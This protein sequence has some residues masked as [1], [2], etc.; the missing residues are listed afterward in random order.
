MQSH[1]TT[2]D[3]STRRHRPKTLTVFAAAFAAGAVLAY[4]VNR[5][6]D[7]HVVQ[8]EPQVESEPIFVALRSL[9]QGSPVTVWDVALKD[10]PKAMLPTT[11]LKAD[12]SLEGFVLRHA[13]REG[14]PL[15]S[16][17]LVRDT[18]TL[19]AAAVAA[20]PPQSLLA[21]IGAATLAWFRVSFGSGMVPGSPN[22]ARPGPMARIRTVL[23][24]EP[25]T[26]K[27]AVRVSPAP[28]CLSADTLTKRG[29]EVVKA[30]LGVE[31]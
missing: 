20:L 17:Q 16:V 28:I 23:D 2:S 19:P 9:P 24:P 8:V 26:T 4:G 11:A 14:Q 13:V 31:S 18:G 22:C 15:L 1:A 25:P 21:L 3:P 6:V 5:V 10:W 30:S 29:V 12:A 27:P 7:V